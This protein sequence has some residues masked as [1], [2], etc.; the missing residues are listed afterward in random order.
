MRSCPAKA[1]RVCDGQA[2]VIEER[3]IACGNCYKVCAQQAKEIRS[4]VEATY[5]LLAGDAPVIACL[6]PSFPAAFP[7]A[8]P[9]QIISAVRALGF[10]EVLEVAFGAQL[11][12]QEYARLFKESDG[13]LVI[14]STCP[15][16]T[17]YVQKYVPSLVPNLAPIVSPAIALGR[18]VKQQYRPGAKTVFFGP[19]VAKKAEIDEPEVAGAIDIAQ[20]FVGLKRM[21]D[22]AGIE[23]GE[24]PE[25]QPDGPLPGVARI[26]PVPGG[27]LR[28][29][30]L[31][32]DVLDNAIIVAEGMENSINL[33]RALSRGELQAR[34]VD[35]LFCEG[36][37]DGP[38]IGSDRSLFARK[39]AVSN[40]VR[41]AHAHTSR[42]QAA[43]TLATYAC[44]DLTRE[45]RAQ[46]VK[47]AQPTEE[48]IGQILDRIQKREVQD[49]LNCGACGYATCRE[50]A[51]AVHEGLAEIEMCLPYLIEQLQSN[52]RKLEEYQRELQE[53]QAQLVQSEKLA[54]VGQLAAGIAHELNNP[55]GTILI[56]S[57]LLLNELDPESQ[58]HKDLRLILDETTRCKQI[59]A[60]LL[61]FARQRQ[62]L[63][64]PTDVNQVLDEVLERT[65]KQQAFAGIV[66]ERNLDPALPKTLADPNQLREVFWNLLINAAE[67][68]PDGGLITV[69]TQLSDDKQQIMIDVADTGI[70]ISEEGIGQVFTPFYTTKPTGTGLGLAI[71]Y[72][73]VKMHRG[74]ISVS[75]RLGEGSRFRV[76][77]PVR[78]EEEAESRS[79]AAMTYR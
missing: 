47:A 25:S 76:T 16:V 41:S 4:G 1:I 17:S 72:G 51:I 63:A 62:I 14:S 55:L 52:L 39:E 10:A 53:T 9:G 73:I 21:L 34:F 38:T 59:V 56:Y 77:L 24:Q 33:L 50:K 23:V 69:S 49:Q 70:G 79:R 12:A 67:A 35:I 65:D 60:G 78:R 15:A 29:A 66:I 18:V 5:E 58:Q 20:S 64:Q 68:M 7:N 28:S 40:Y 46:P 8:Q 30:A 37:I 11:V 75:S 45:F 13:E 42:E 57:H 19:C 31:Q 44:V 71:T 2:Q 26:F 3:C 74:D 48:E 36:C 6:A 32:A 43:S 61:D 22:R 27:L 54:S